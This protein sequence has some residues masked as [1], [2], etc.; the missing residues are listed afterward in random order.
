MLYK[1]YYYWLLIFGEGFSKYHLK[2]S[3]HL[4]IKSIFWMTIDGY[5]KAVKNQENKFKYKVKHTLHKY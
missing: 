1:I 2:H 4:N 5:K 3:M